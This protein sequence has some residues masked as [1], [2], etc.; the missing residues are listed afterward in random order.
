MIV[1]P[2]IAILEVRSGTGGGE[3]KIWADDLLRMYIRYC[4]RKDF[5]VSQVADSTVKI[6]GNEVY[7][8][9][10][11]ETGVHRVQRVPVTEKRGRVHTSA[12][13]VIVM[14]QISSSEIKISSDDVEWDFFRS[15]GKG[16]QNVNKVSTAVRLR[17]AP[18]GIIIES[19]QER[20]QEA[21]KQIALNLLSSQLWQIEEEKKQKT[22][23]GRRSQAGT[24]DRSEKIRTYNYAQNRVTDHRTG[25]SWMQ[26][27]NVI[28]GDLGIIL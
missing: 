24:G 9:L 10:K 28:S 27:K 17:H 18:T 5:S 8:L 2:N 22:L 16:G 4:N 7:N 13:V 6:K 26:L 23:S 11:N 20:T 14:P 21:N 15:G 25:N 3:A 19:S 1:N 12:A